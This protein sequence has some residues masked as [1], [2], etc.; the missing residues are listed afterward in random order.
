MISK[1]D[2]IEISQEKPFANCKLGRKKYA[3]I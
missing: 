1:L 2:D 3:E